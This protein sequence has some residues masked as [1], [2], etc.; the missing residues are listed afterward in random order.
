MSQH[1][2]K[3]FVRPLTLASAAIVIHI[4]AATA[5]DLKGDAQQRMKEVLTGTTTAHFAPQSEPLD[6]K[7]TTRSVDSQ[8]S[9]RQ[10]LLGIT[11]SRARNTETIKHSEIA[12]AS[13]RTEIRK[14]PVANGDT[15]AA[16][17]QVLLGQHH[18]RDAS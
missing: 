12:G 17:R 5:G 6:A 7:V 15:Q 8:E 13:G 18:A 9:V 10:L 3:F 14:R 1:I 4:G 11:A 2:A 16:V